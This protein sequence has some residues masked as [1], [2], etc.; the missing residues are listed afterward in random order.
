MRIFLPIRHDVGSERCMQDNASLF[1]QPAG[2]KRG[3]RILCD[4][5]YEKYHET[6]LRSLTGFA[7]KGDLKISLTGAP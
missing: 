4:Q 3:L 2:A 7:R 6:L 1:P 5:S